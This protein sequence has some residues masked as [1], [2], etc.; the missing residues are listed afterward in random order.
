MKNGFVKVAAATPDIRVADVEFNTQNIINAM[1]E[2]QK[3]GAKILVFP[4][5]CVTGY[6]CSDLFDHSVLLKASRKALLEIAENTNDKDMLVFVGAPLEVNGKLYNVAAAMNQGEII[7]F[8]TKTFLPNYGEFYEMRQFT[9]GPQTVREI[10]FE[11]KKIPFGPQILFQAEGMEELVVAAEICE[12][13]WSPVP[14]SIQ[15]ALEGATVIVNCSA[16]DETI[17]KDTYRRAL[18]SGQSA[19][20]ISG[21]IY[22][23]AGEGESTT[24][25]VFGGHNIIA[26]NGTILKESSRYVNEII[27]SEIDLQRITGERRKNT[28][29]QPLDEETLVRVPFIIEETKTFLTRTFPKKPFV[30]S[31]EQTR[32]QRCEEILTIQAMGLKKRL[33]HTNARTAVVGISGGLDSTLALLVTARAFDMLG[34]D[35]KDIIAVT[36]PCFGTTDRTYQNACEMSKKVGATLIEVPIA[37][38]VNVHF[39][40]IGHDPEDHSVTYENCQARE[41]TQVL[42]DIANKTWGMVIGTGDLSELALGWATYNGDHMSMY[43]V[44]AS[45]PKTLV[46]HLVKYAADDTKDEALKNVLYDVL[47]TPVSPELLPPK[48]GDIAQKTEDLVGPYELHDFFLYFMLRFG[49]EPSKIF[50]IAC[51]TFDGEYDKETIFKWLETFCR[52]FFS[53]QFK[54]SCL[55]DGPKIGTVALSP[56]GDWRMPS[57]ACVAVWMKD[58]EAC[59]V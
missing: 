15:A 57:D 8:T 27:Y 58:L 5:L 11:G 23:N 4:E 37:D 6:T 34:R 59:R 30:P 36:M 42:M 33:A 32:A 52:R 55:P 31:D 21:Y 1:E 46:R 56:R 45:V 35:K 17:G 13:V 49:Y 48:D 47:D 25:L 39:R 29:F 24:D 10:T 18:I 16:S 38:A 20:L 22:A 2:A 41:R 51:M 43:G 12:D 3:N 44:N 26:E 53:Q 28:T 40:D 9:P 50:R 7:G 14:P 54:R 19:R